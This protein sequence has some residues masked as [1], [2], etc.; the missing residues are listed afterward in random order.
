M[1]DLLVCL[2]GVHSSQTLYC[3]RIVVEMYFD[4]CHKVVVR[5][6]E[7]VIRKK[8]ETLWPGQKKVLFPLS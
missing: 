7:R 4:S 8:L 5:M 6:A 3:L 2:K 1:R